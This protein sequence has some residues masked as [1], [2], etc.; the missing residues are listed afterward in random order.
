MC[1]FVESIKL[2][3][4]VFFR[5]KY[6]QER[7]NK[8]FENYFPDEDPIKIFDSLNQVVLPGEGV[9]KLRLVYDTDV[10]SLD[11]SHY[12]R[13]EI[14]SLKLV[15]TAIESSP[16]KFEDRKAYNSA[17]E[18]REKCDD[19]LLV[20]NGLLTDASFYNVA[21]FDGDKWIT[22]KEPLIYGTN[23]A[24]LMANEWIVEDDIKV[25][26]LQK[27]KKICLF[28]AMIEFEELVVDISSII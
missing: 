8:T 26:D 6:H 10:L 19:V 15:E 11:F 12:V 5:L 20:R 21:L 16:Y 13:R 1:R 3:D 18:N 23:R 17:F 7:V 24:E 4:G 27:F 14:K 2:K 28:N 9:F 25:E 22:P